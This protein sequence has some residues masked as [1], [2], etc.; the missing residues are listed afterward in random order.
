[1]A[2]LCLLEL[3]NRYDFHGLIA[4]GAATDAYRG[5]LLRLERPIRQCKTE[6]EIAQLLYDTFESEK[7][8]EV[9]QSDYLTA[10]NEIWLLLRA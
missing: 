10:A 5:A 7:S 8:T 6:V 9:D 1:V 2:H 4:N 3:L